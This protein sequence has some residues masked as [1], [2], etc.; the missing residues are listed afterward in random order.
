[1]YL[2]TPVFGYCDSKSGKF[3]SKANFSFTVTSYCNGDRF[4]FPSWQ[5]EVRDRKKVSFVLVPE[6]MEKSKE[7]TNHISSVLKRSF[8]LSIPDK[9][10]REY[11]RAQLINHINTK[12]VKRLIISYTGKGNLF[13]NFTIINY[14]IRESP[15]K[16]ITKFAIGTL[17]NYMLVCMVNSKIIDGLEKLITKFT[18]KKSN[19]M[20]RSSQS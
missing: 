19:H 14:E 10:F 7:I 9:K 3:H 20:I 6:Y 2:G 1:M 12:D 13:T 5:L 16:H 8:F 4:S 17:C 18:I 15:I 11:F